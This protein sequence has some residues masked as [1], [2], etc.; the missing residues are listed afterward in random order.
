MYKKLMKLGLVLILA[1]S[2]VAGLNPPKATAAAKTI[3]YYAK[4]GAYI[5]KGKSTKSKKLKL[6]N[7][8]QKVGTKTSKKASY[9]KVKVG[10]T[11]GYVAKSQMYTKPTWVYKANYKNIFVYKN[12]KKTSSTHL[13]NAKG[14]SLVSHKKPSSD[15]VQITYKGKN[16]YT[17]SLNINIDYKINKVRKAFKAIKH[18]TKR[19]YESQSAYS[20][21]YYFVNKGRA[22]Q[23]KAKLKAYGFVENKN[24]DAL[25]TFRYKGYDA[26]KYSDYNFRVAK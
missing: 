10:K 26:G 15:F 13:K 22:N 14:A 7:Q 16:Y 24:G 20:N 6:L 1:L 12:A 18:K 8:N 23:L 11:S 21:Y 25:Y 4:E 3:S 9:F 17:T 5:Y 2:V 19:D